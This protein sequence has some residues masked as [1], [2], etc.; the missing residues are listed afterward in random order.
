MNLNDIEPAVILARGQY[1][2]VNGEYKTA[3]SLL[4]TRV[5]GACDALRHALQNDTDRI[6]LIDQ[7]A[8]LLSEIRETSVIAAQLKAQKDELWEAAWGGKK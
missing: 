6:Q 2:T 8:I 7:T 5:Q 3:M 1:A 4:Q